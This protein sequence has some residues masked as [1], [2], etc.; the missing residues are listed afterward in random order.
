MACCYAAYVVGLV[1]SRSVSRAGRSEEATGDDPGWLAGAGRLEQCSCQ[2]GVLT[3]TGLHG[4]L[5]W[6][7]KAARL[8]RAPAN[9][10]KT[11]DPGI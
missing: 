1:Q 2:Y 10:S 7:G 11:R 6:R 3:P 4:A 9:A 8:P 5:C